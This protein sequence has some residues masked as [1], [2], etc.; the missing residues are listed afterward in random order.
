MVVQALGFTGALTALLAG[1]GVLLRGDPPQVAR[2]AAGGAA[3][4]PEPVAASA[5]VAPGGSLSFVNPADGTAA[6]LVR[7]EDG[8]LAALGAVCTHAGCD[9]EWRNGRVLCP[10][11]RSTFDLRTGEPQRGPAQLPLPVITVTERD[12]Q[13]LAG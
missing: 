13:I 2:A 12:G 8:T 1:V 9:V 5:D 11:H 10:C 7:E 6:L 4:A 3:P